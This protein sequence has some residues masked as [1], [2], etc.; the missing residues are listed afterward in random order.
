MILLLASALLIEQ[1]PLE[2]TRDSCAFFADETS[3]LRD[4]D[5][6]RNSAYF[7]VDAFPDWTCRRFV[8]DM[9]HAGF[10]PLDTTDADWEVRGFVW[11]S[12]QQPRAFRLVVADTSATLAWH[13]FDN[14]NQ[15]SHAERSVPD[16]DL[17]EMLSL[18]E[19]V[20]HT[21]I[22]NSVPVLDGTGWLIEYT[23]GNRYC[24]YRSSGDT[25]AHFTQLETLMQNHTAD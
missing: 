3:S 22:D 12:F 24:L 23:D 2:T 6:A 1:W 25:P 18:I 15:G 14:L 20:C 8:W 4:Q 10:A 11:P 17:I 21:P 9:A 13:E 5:F 7:P 19:T 16:S